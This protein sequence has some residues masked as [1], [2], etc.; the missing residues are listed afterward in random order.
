[1]AIAI[2]PYRT[3]TLL[4]VSMMSRL[5]MTNKRTSTALAGVCL[6]I[7]LTNSMPM[8]NWMVKLKNM[9]K[10]DMVSCSGPK[11]GIRSN[12]RRMASALATMMPTRIN[13]DKKIS[14]NEDILDTIA[15]NLYFK[16]LPPFYLLILL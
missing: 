4:P 7:I 16:S 9:L 14:A 3:S 13:T 12:N 2:T 15:L 5:A 6:A 1:M 11:V 10:Y 8:I